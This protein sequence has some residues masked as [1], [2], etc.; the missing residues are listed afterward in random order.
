MTVMPDLAITELQSRIEDCLQQQLEQHA[1]PAEQLNQAMSYST[2]SGGKRLR[3]LLVYLSGQTLNVP[4]DRL[5]A[6]AVAIELIH[7]Y[8]LV[9]DDLP[10]M[11][12]DDLRR[13]RATCHRAFDEATAIL[14]GDSLQSLAFQIIAQDTQTDISAGQRLAMIT[15][16]A[17]ASG[18]QGMAAGQALDLSELALEHVELSQLEKVHRLKTG[19]LLQCCIELALAANRESTEIQQQSLRSYATHLGLAFQMQD[20][21]LDRYGETDTLGKPQGSDLEQGKCTYATL[22][23]KTTLVQLIEQHYTGAMESLTPLGQQAAGLID[24][25]RHILK[26]SS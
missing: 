2:L 3:P 5:D 4:F 19:R 22:Y 11:D 23:P 15:C 6:C 1:G 21:Y 18:M 8:S 17:H 20:D 13:G 26:R 24:F 16:L 10:A 7:C 14:V 25:T 12:D 9:H